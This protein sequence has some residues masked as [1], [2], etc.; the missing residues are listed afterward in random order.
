MDRI[1]REL[2]NSPRVNPQ[3]LNSYGI[4]DP[5][6]RQRQEVVRIIHGMVTKYN[7]MADMRRR[8][9]SR[10]L[11]GFQ[12]KEMC[13]ILTKLQVYQEELVNLHEDI[14]KAGGYCPPI[15]AILLTTPKLD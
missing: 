5:V 2:E 3:E 10:K 14:R 12:G 7:V 1:I 8:F 6:L 11:H 9:L 4:P 15:P 13:S